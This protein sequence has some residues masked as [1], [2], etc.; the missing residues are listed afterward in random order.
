MYGSAG[1]TAGLPGSYPYGGSGIAPSLQPQNIY[2]VGAAP[3]GG[4]YYPGGQTIMSGSGRER[5]TYHAPPGSTIVIKG[6]RHRSQR[7][8]DSGHRHSHHKRSR[9]SEPRKPIVIQPGR[10]GF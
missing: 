2:P 3:G 9:S 4:N 6:S 1:S 5:E 8:S 10:Y 7:S